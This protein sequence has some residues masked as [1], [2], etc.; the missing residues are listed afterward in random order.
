MA[1]E[2]P[3]ARQLPHC[4]GPTVPVCFNR[5]DLTQPETVFPVRGFMYI[6]CDQPS[7]VSA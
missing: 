4:C 5:A 6:T 1:V 3:P 7:S 2:L